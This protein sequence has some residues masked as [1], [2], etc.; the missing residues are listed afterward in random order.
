MNATEHIGS[1]IAAGRRH[2]PTAGSGHPVRIALVVDF[3]PRKLGSLEEWLIVF[4]A[5]AERRRHRLDVFTLEPVHPTVKAELEQA[6][7]RWRNLRELTDRPLLTIR[8]LARDYDVLHLNGFAPR[9]ALSCAAYLARPA[10]VLFVDRVSGQGDITPTLS[11]LQRALDR[12][13]ARGMARLV[14]ISNYVRDRDCA[15]FGM[16]ALFARTIYDGVNMSRFRP[17]SSPRVAGSDL[18]VLAAA[19]LIPEKGIEQLLRALAM[20]PAARLSIAGDGP[21]A[22]YLRTLSETLGLS[23]RV[24][25]LG[26]HD[27]IARLLQEADVFV[28]PATWA[29]AFGLTVAEAMAAGRAVVASR[30][31]AVSELIVDGETGLLVPPGDVP[32]LASALE[33]LATQP[34]FRQALGDNARRRAEAH[35]DLNRCVEQHLDLCEEITTSGGRK[36]GN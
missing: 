15:R 12:F 16:T 35:F 22:A 17:L 10:Q 26:L 21:Q 36:E 32:A 8:R 13:T 33:S 7:A 23:G 28:H 9:H 6:G 19:N 1:P 29:E 30:T 14:G 20:V 3:A 25:F 27:D 18:R 4:A 11:W 24:K 2:Q 5:E 34:E 31:G